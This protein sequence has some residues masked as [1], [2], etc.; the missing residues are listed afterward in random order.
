MQPGEPARSNSRNP[1]KVGLRVVTGTGR[2]PILRVR[3]PSGL[4]FS[5]RMQCGSFFRY[6]V[7]SLAATSLLNKVE[8]KGNAIGWMRHRP[9]RTGKLTEAQREIWTYQSL[10]PQHPIQQLAY[11]LIIIGDFDPGAFARAIAAVIAVHEPL[12]T[13]YP[14]RGGRPRAVV[15]HQHSV[16]AEIELRDIADAKIAR[17]VFKDIATAPYNLA[18]VARCSPPTRRRERTGAP[19]SVVFA[20]RRSPPRKADCA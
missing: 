1:R 4:N 3:I 19:A 18:M 5:S 11:R 12:R 16:R 20:K 2:D 17:A 14:V 8:A 15:L 13:I 6:V 9:L 10:A 7:A